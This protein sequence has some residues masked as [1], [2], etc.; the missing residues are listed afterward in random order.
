MSL[1][2]QVQGNCAGDENG[3][4]ASTTNNASSRKSPDPLLDTT[5]GVSPPCPT[6]LWPA[7][8]RASPC[9]VFCGQFPGENVKR[10][11]TWMRVRGRGAALWTPCLVHT[12]K[13]LCS[14]DPR[15]RT[16]LNDLL[17]FGGST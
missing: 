4:V 12:E 7:E 16:D 3:L 5:I 9:W 14:T 6:M 10:F 15:D 8:T 17:A 11:R 13:I 1:R 2:P